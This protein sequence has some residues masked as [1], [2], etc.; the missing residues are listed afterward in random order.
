LEL[1]STRDYID[2]KI[3]KHTMKKFSA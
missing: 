3:K 1:F 2:E